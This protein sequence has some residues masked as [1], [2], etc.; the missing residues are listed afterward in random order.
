MQGRD[1][2]GAA[3][4]PDTALLAKLGLIRTKTGLQKGARS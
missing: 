4:D 3:L 2:S 1:L